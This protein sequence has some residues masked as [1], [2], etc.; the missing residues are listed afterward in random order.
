MSLVVLQEELATRHNAIYPQLFWAVGAVSICIPGICAS[1]PL[2]LRG[3]P[4]VTN[5][6][7]NHDSHLKHGNQIFQK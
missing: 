5:P 4:H 3:D 1:A 7:T 6:V 2:T